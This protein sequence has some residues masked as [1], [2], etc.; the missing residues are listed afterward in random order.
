MVNK[1]KKLCMYIDRL[2]SFVRYLRRTF[3]VVCSFFLSSGVG[4]LWEGTKKENSATC[5]SNI[6]PVLPITFISQRVSNA[7]RSS[8]KAFVEQMRTI[9]N[10]PRI[11]PDGVDK[12]QQ[13]SY[14]KVA[15]GLI[16]GYSTERKFCG[17]VRS[18]RKSEKRRART[19]KGDEGGKKELLTANDARSSNLFNV[20]SCISDDPMAC[21]KLKQS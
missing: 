14:E 6:S 4:G 10:S 20:P 9:W 13:L 18:G 16:T 1:E 17:Q 5:A 15:P 3:F 19:K 12:G 2:E 21:R 8:D 11:A 7:Q